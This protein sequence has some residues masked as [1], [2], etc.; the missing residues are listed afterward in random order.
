MVFLVVEWGTLEFL[1]VVALIFARFRIY[2]VAKKTRVLGTSSGAVVGVDVFERPANT[3]SRE[4]RSLVG[5]GAKPHKTIQKPHKTIQK[6]H[7]TIQLR[8]SDEIKTRLSVC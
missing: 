5:F 8:K 1:C 7:N 6:P 3:G 4:P 2:A